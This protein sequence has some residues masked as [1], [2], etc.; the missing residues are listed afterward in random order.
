MARIGRP[1]AMSV[2]ERREAVYSAAEALFGARG[3][4][5][6]TMTEIASAAGMS[7]KTLYQH[8]ADKEALL[9]G[10]MKSSYIWSEN[11]FETPADDPLD[12]LRHR[13]RVVAR[14]D[15]HMRPKQTPCPA[16]G[17]RRRTPR[18]VGGDG[19][20]PPTYWV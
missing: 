13:L 19:I 16:A 15:A 14:F 10:L 20:E 4:E 12:G 18:L 3:Y 2:E 6:V 9:R 5:K 7:K 1:P 11:A 17:A 8:F